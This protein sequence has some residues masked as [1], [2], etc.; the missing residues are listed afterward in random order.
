M[1]L[2][3]VGATLL[4]LSGCIA[5]P[6]PHERRI[7]PLY[8]GKV[9]DA[10]TGQP[11]ES[12]NVSVRTPHFIKNEDTGLPLEA[13]TKTDASGYYEIGVTKKEIWFVFFLGP[14]EGSC[15][16]TVLFS[17]PTYEPHEMQTDQFRGAAV[18]GMCTGAKEKR[19]VSLK[20]KSSN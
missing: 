12:V 5:L 7:T 3:L 20:R 2:I 17:H 19:N 14:A 16:G 9:T 10:V 1:R 8:Q 18:D 11:I 4:T 13:E 6:I 15:G